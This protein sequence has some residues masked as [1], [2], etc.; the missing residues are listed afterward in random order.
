[1]RALFPAM[2]CAAPALPGASACILALAL[3][4]LPGPGQAEA[5]EPP[6]KASAEARLEALREALLEHALKVPARVR[7]SAWVD[8]SG[9]LRENVQISSDIKVRG[10]RLLSALDDPDPA[11]IRL[12]AQ[13]AASV[14]RSGLRNCAATGTRLK[15]HAAFSSEASPPHGR[16]GDHYI[17]AL[18]D[19]AEATLRALFAQDE[20][21][22]LTSTSTANSAYERLLDGPERPQ[23][24]PYHMRLHIEAAPP[25]PLIHARRALRVTP[26]AKLLL[27]VSLQ[28]DDRVSGRSLWQEHA[29]LEYPEPSPSLMRPE[30]PATLT[31]A[32]QHTL[33]TWQQALQSALACEPLQFAASVNEEEGQGEQ[34]AIAA[35]SRVGIRVGDQL[36]LIDRSRYPG[37]LLE[38]DT[39]RLAALLEVQTVMRD[40]AITRRIA[41]PRPAAQ[42]PSLVAVPL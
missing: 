32:L 33:R 7:S 24:Q 42:H 23:T 36:L 20:G 35:G 2:R 27:R 38:G 22:V 11:S 3:S 14:A 31:Y 21:W 5:P 26:P 17:A 34:I 18:A 30:L 1:M 6:P 16:P 41:G 19:S 13:T 39:L 10:I 12:A 40:T 8:E 28:L 4:A 37:Q 25:G 15:R 29:L 9:V